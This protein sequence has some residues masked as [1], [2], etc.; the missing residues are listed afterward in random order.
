MMAKEILCGF[1]LKIQS[2]RYCRSPAPCGETYHRGRTK[3][4]LIT[5]LRN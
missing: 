4:E 2:I 3:V 5:P 1:D